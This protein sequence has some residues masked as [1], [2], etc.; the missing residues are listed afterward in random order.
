MFF[1]HFA[2]KNQLPG[3]SVTRT[4]VENGLN[5]MN[6]TQQIL[7]RRDYI[8]E[9]AAGFYNSDEIIL[10][11]LYVRFAGN[12]GED[13]QASV[14]TFFFPFFGIKSTVDSDLF[15]AAGSILIHGLILFGY[16]SPY[17][18]KAVIFMLLSRKMASNTFITDS[19]LECISKN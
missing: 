7:I 8:L 6:T 16:V 9:N 10:S 11:K 13:L 5:G 14:D 2:S 4:L 17:L 1:K 19:Y 3:L 18:N 12:Q 15:A